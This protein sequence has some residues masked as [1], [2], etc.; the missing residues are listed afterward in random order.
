MR[1]ILVI[2]ATGSLGKVVTENLSLQYEVT[3]TYCH[4]KHDER[5]T[6]IRYLKLDVTDKFDFEKLEH[7]YDCIVLIS[8]AMPATMHGY[9]PQKY[10]DVNITGTLNT[11]E[12]CKK[13]KVRKMIFV[14]SFSD[15]AGSFYSGIPITTEQPR[16][17]AMTGDH[18]VY[19]ISKATACDLIEHY[20]QEYGLQTVIFRI[21]TVYCADDNVNYFVDGSKRTKAYVQ[22]IRNVV[23]YQRIEVWGDPQ[24]A[25]D[26]PYVKDFSRLIELAVKSKTAQGL[27]NAGTGSPVSLEQLVDTIIEIFGEDNSI[28]KVFLP[29]KNSQPNFTF[30]MS[31]TR[32][33]FGFVPEYD[34]RRMFLDIRENVDPL[35]W[36][37]GDK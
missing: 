34:L 9:Q 13:T 20:H 31:R 7:V 27:Y 24:N 10:I 36:Q 15:V 35:V 2:G 11:L 16:S 32:A 3:G 22:M 6:N 33:E 26:M 17:L 19:G 28:E 5:I 12:F 1:K 4:S 25:K 18:A 30:D 29:E 23:Q 21:P 14:M 8:G 37:S